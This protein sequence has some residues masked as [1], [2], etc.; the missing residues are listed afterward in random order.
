ML[1]VAR[2]D[3]SSYT[4]PFVAFA[5]NPLQRGELSYRAGISE[6]LER[7]VA[8]DILFGR[9]LAFQVIDY[10]EHIVVYQEAREKMRDRTRSEEFE[11]K[12]T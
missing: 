11:K 10:L 7:Y 12:R 9:M 4:Y 3:H 6:L 1:F 2:L 8:Q 5:F